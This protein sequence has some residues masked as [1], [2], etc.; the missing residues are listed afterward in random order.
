MFIRKVLVTAF[1]AFAL[2]CASSWA[3]TA[4][5]LAAIE[6][7]QQADTQSV[8]GK[9]LT[10]GD[11]TFSI[12][13]QKGTDPE[14]VEFVTDKNTKIEGK[15]QVGSTASVDYRTENKRNVAVRVVVTSEM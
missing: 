11:G 9:V 8:S 14:K 5:H 10:V 1:A 7:Q 2:V 13:V 3:A 15:L 4:S 6:S 12:E